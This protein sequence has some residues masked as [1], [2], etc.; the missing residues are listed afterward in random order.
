MIKAI[1]FVMKLDF[2]AL[3][4][5]PQGSAQQAGPCTMTHNYCCMLL[6]SKIISWPFLLDN[7]E[8]K[9]DYCAARC[10]DRLHISAGH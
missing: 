2:L 5:T 10:K 1:V 4:K 6:L 7:V 8:I 3:T 9:P